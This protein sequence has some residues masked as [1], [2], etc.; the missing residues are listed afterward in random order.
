MPRGPKGEKRSQIDDLKTAYHV[1]NFVREVSWLRREWD[2][3]KGT[4]LEV[5]IFGTAAG[6]ALLLGWWS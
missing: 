1:V 6:L 5:L 4:L 3:L 2:S